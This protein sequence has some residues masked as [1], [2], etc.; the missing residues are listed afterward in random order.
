[1]WTDLKCIGFYLIVGKR[2]LN[3]ELERYPYTWIQYNAIQYC[4][5]LLRENIK[6]TSGVIPIKTSLLKTYGKNVIKYKLKCLSKPSLSV[7]RQKILHALSWA[8]YCPVRTN[9]WPA[10][11]T[12]SLFILQILH[13]PNLSGQVNWILVSIFVF[14]CLWTE[15]EI[16]KHPKKHLANILSSWPHP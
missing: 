13:C 16:R 4:C 2:Q 11:K 6:E 5:Y 12:C 15:M 14:A 1:M 3:L 8:L 9:R 7:S 10:R